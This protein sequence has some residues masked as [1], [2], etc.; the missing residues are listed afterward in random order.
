MI[1]LEKMTL[2]ELC[3]KAA[4]KFKNRLAFEIY[5]D[6]K[7]YDPVSYRLL[8]IRVR[9]FASLLGSLGVKA[10]DRVMILSENCPEWPIAFFGTALAGAVAVPVLPD[11]TQDQI[12]AITAHAGVSVFCVTERTAI[13]INTLEAVIPRVYLDTL[14]N[15]ENAGANG[16]GTNVGIQVSLGRIS[17]RLPLREPGKGFAFPLVNEDEPA[18]I[19][20]TSG[21]SGASKGVLLSHRNFIFCALSSRR[22]MKIFPRDRLLSVIPLAHTYECT[23]GLLAAVLNGAS[24]TYLDKPPSPVVLLPAI[25]AIRPTA[26]VTVPL[27]IEKIYRQKIVPTLH[28]SPLYKWCVTRPLALY[29]AG[30]K[31]NAAFGG[32]VRFFGIGG[33]PLAADVEDF[34]R[35]IK[36]PYAPGYGLTEAAPL[37]AGTAPY[38]FPPHSAG[39]ILPGV[40]LRIAPPAPGFA[41]GEIQARGP[42]IMQGYYRDE[43]ATKNA[44]TPDLWL[45]TGD[46]GCLNR[47]GY[48]F[49]R[50]RIKAVILGPSGENIY[51]EEIEI[52]LSAS[53]LTEEVLVRSGE[54]GQPEALLVLNGEAKK[55]RQASPETFDRELEDLKNTVNRRLP[56]FSRI[57]R[58]EIRGEP[59]EKTPTQKIKRYLY[60]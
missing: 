19:I 26:M 41:E 36:F 33:A 1:S 45:K 12:G 31:L 18:A 57:N 13:K 24:I 49:I 43:A 5:R 20:Y 48:L 21:A 47:K 37:L 56:P 50:G 40:E 15:R 3:L 52:L 23:L 9:Q 32:S 22:L 11:F 58:I 28:A 44:F 10:G 7:I 38:R 16:A 54:H 39:S 17:K 60:Q 27:F 35:Q 53:P 29:L 42:N 55:R 14:E 51:P 25:Q 4:E 2:A 8:G 59:F 6:G 30:R 34:L 46:L